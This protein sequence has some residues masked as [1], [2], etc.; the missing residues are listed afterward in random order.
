MSKA[1]VTPPS[2]G[3]VVKWMPD[4]ADGYGFIKP[5]GEACDIYV[6]AYD[7]TVGKIFEGARVEFWRTPSKIMQGRY[8]AANVRVL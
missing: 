3:T 7:V 1:K 6:Q 5:D 4:V 2:K 8:H